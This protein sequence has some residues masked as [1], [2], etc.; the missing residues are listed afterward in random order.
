[1]R[2]YIDSKTTSSLN[3]R[4]ILKFRTLARNF[5]QRDFTLRYKQT[6]I[7]LAWGII[8][9]LMN[10]VI[11]GII[12]Q[13]IDKSQNPAQSFI[14]VSSGVIIWQLMATGMGDINSSLVANSGI[15]SKVYFPKIILPVSSLLVTLVDF[16]ISFSIF[17]VIFIIS[18]GF[19][20]WQIIF[21]PVFVFLGLVLALGAGIFFAT[22]NVKFRDVNF[23]LPFI[24]QVAFY[25]SPVFLKTRFFLDLHIPVFLKYI[26]L[27]NPATAVIDG[28]RMCLFGTPVFYEGFPSWLFFG[29]IAIN[30]LVLVLG[31]RYF[32]R[33][34][35]TFADYI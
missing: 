17:L 34:E 3:I 10:I 27:L 9:P 28:F 16:V 8:K 6:W 12:S 25:I 20:G 19:P 23:I 33:F 26:F 2:T 29:S 21:F 22:L 32:L 18:N 1:M 7:G 13:F 4:E 11:F 35:K 30:F 24:L 14:N 31:V 5:A 15:L